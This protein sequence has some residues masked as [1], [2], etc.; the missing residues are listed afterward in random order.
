MS[1]LERGQGS[2]NVVLHRPAEPAAV[3]VPQRC[4]ERAAAPDRSASS[5]PAT[6]HVV[7]VRR[8]T[9]PAAGRRA[10]SARRRCPGSAPGA[11][12]IGVGADQPVQPARPARSSRGG[13]LHLLHG[14]EVRAVRR[15]QPRRV[16][17]GQL[18][19]VQNG[20][21]GPNAGCR[22][23][24][25]S[26][27]SST[28]ERWRFGAGRCVVGRVGVRNDQGQPVAGPAQRSTTSMTAGAASR[29]RG[30]SRRRSRRR[31]WCRRAASAPLRT[32]RRLIGGVLGA[33]G[34]VS[35]IRGHLVRNSGESRKVVSSRRIDQLDQRGGRG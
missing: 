21:S 4:R 22:P 18:P 32:P 9:S 10:R 14:G 16:D 29:G 5:S 25:P 12:S 15:G 6:W 28:S 17:G 24:I 8:P 33:A 27:A 31:S 30:A 20:S 1:G 23:N 35:V 26:L 7:D 13:V 2:S 34:W 11:A 3:A 19:A